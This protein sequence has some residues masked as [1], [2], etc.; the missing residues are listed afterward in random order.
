MKLHLDTDIGGDL[1][2]LCALAMLLRWPGIELTCITTAAEQS[3]RRAGYVRYTLALAGRDD[4]PVAA[5][6]DV[7]VP[8]YR[9]VSEYP[10]DD[11]LWPELIAPAPGPVEDALRLLKRS[12][13][14]G[15]VIV[16][17]G[18]FTNLRLLDEAYPGILARANLVLMGGSVFPIREGYP[19]FRNED[20]YNIQ[21]DMP[22]ARYVLERSNPLFVT[23]SVTVE[24]ALRRSYAPAL[25]AAGPLGDL[26]ARQTE[27]WTSLNPESA[28][29]GR[30]YSGLPDDFVNFQH[31]PLACA[32][33]LGWD[34]VSIEEV[35]LV[36]TERDGWLHERQ[37]TAG[38]PMRVV[39][40][41]DGPRF[42]ALWLSIVTWQSS[43]TSKSEPDIPFPRY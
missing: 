16:G 43:R 12:I 26:L 17:I 27:A 30:T 18:P 15:A 3:G 37:D 20:D 9:Y 14:A 39:T 38:R 24:T 25:R 1:D 29:Y 8:P 2:D 10:P 7:A 4:I 36:V 32:A 35:P 23:L 40:R 41:V 11:V 28:Q 5:G 42:D 31:D 33:A 6:K 13:E 22:S 21:V 19:R 34:G